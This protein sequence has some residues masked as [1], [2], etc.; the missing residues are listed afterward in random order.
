MSEQPLSKKY[1]FV[2]HQLQ[3]SRQMIHSLKEK[4][5]AKRSRAEKMADW[6]TKT[7]GS[8]A[9]LMVNL[10]WF[11]LWI[12]VNLE[13]IPGVTAFDPF[14]F[15]L[16]T[17]I[18]SLEAIILAI[19]VLISQNRAEEIVDLREEIDLQ[20]NLLTER[21]LTKVMHIVCAIAEK[22]GID[23]SQD[24]ELQTMLQPAPMDKIEQALEEQVVGKSHNR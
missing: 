12:A 4:Q 23:L 22:Q 9:F 5:E 13:S 17:M 14:P 10:F 19:F 7:F 16:L 15:G 21:E 3:Q 11:A 18:V 1:H 2:H 8:M 24:D 20:V 6:M